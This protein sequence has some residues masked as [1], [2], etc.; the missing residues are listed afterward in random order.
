MQRYFHSWTQNFV[1]APRLVTYCVIESEVRV[2]DY[3]ALDKVSGD[4]PMAA[5][6]AVRSLSNP[7]PTRLVL[8][9][10]SRQILPISSS[11]AIHSFKPIFSTRS[12]SEEGAHLQ[13]AYVNS[14][15]G[16]IDTVTIHPQD[17]YL[18]TVS[19]PPSTG[20]SRDKDAPVIEDH[21]RIPR[22]QK[23]SVSTSKKSLEP[24]DARSLKV[25]SCMSPL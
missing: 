4:Q 15:E 17:P 21:S 18:S 1:P 19:R 9:T 11:S 20:Q 24:K 14:M 5:T 13:I 8:K 10:S 2:Q 6:I 7:N 23:M 12:F 16:H 22:D 3:T 25:A